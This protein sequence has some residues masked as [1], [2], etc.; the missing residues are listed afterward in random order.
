MTWFRLALCGTPVMCLLAQP[1]A[2]GPAVP[3]TA[4]PA[5]TPSV[6]A[7]QVVLSVGDVKLTVAQFNQLIE[8]LPEQ[9]RSTARGE[10]R[11]QFA[12]DLVRVLVM[13]QE[14]RRL[15]LNEAP[16]FKTQS[17]FQVDNL[18]AGKVFAQLAQVSDADLHQ[19]FDA[20]KS[21]FE[22]IRARH[23]LVRAAGSPVQL[24]AGKKELSDQEALAKAQELR[25]KIAEGADFA[26]LAGQESDDPGSKAKGGDLGFFHRGQSLP[27]PFEEAAFKMNVGEVS[28]PVKTPFGYHLIRVEAKNPGTFEEAKPDITRR[29]GPQKAQAALDELVKKASVTLDPGFFGQPAA[30]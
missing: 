21:E 13:A 8:M 6:P 14:G 1:P 25:K 5:F 22:Q 16:A 17:E 4:A 11:E 30:K 26:T 10:G 7:D 27:P 3:K 29:L 19:Y 23:I 15:K 18:L 24:E 20:H 2:P 28:D 12:N 9:R